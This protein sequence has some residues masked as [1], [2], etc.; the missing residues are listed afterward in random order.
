M[1][2]P[3]HAFVDLPGR[4]TIPTLYFIGVTTGSSSI[5][6]VFPLWAGELGLQDAVALLDATLAEEKQT[7]ADLTTLAGSLV[8]QEAQAA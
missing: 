3:G 1:N 8:N 2:R 5:R 7:D 6:T 4:A